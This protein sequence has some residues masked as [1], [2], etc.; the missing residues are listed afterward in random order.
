M[1]LNVPNYRADIDGLRAIAII[2]VVLFHM[3]PEYFGGGFVGVDIFFVISGF[4]ITSIILYQL[5]NNTFSFNEFYAKR[6]IRL[7]PSLIIVLISTGL[8]GYFALLPSEFESLGKHSA[9]GATFLS[10]LLLFKEVNYFDSASE[11]KPLLHL[12]SLGIEEQFYIF[13]PLVLFISFKIKPKYIISILAL[14]VVYSFS[15]NILK[16]SNKPEYSFYLPQTRFWELMIGSVLGYFHINKNSIINKQLLNFL[17]TLGF[18]LCVLSFSIIDKNYKFPGFWSLMPVIGTAFLIFSGKNTFINS[19]VLSHRF[20]VSI[21]LISYPLY[22]WHWPLL[23]FSY[24]SRNNTPPIEERISLIILS[25]ILS[26]LTY[27]IIEKPLIKWPIGKKRKKSWIFL[28]VLI[29]VF[30]LGISIY[31]KFIPPYSSNKNFSLI[32]EAVNDWDFPGRLKLIRNKKGDSIYWQGLNINKSIYIGDSNIQQYYP[33][34]EKLVNQ[35]KDNLGL[36]FASGGGCPPFPNL[37][38]DDGK[39]SFCEKWINN[40]FELALTDKNIKKVII[41]AQWTSYFSENSNFYFSFG[42]NKVYLSGFQKNKNLILNEF[43]KMIERL[44]KE[45]KKVYVVLN[46][47]VGPEF[48]PLSQIDRGF[49]RFPLINSKENKISRSSFES[50]YLNLL[51]SIE[52]ISKKSGAKIINPLDYLCNMKS[53]YCDVSIYGKPIYKDNCH[54]RPF[55]VKDFITFLD[56]TI[57]P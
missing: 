6:I 54:L 52:F 13:L 9:A 7:F 12:W 2:A 15:L 41:G 14:S 42:N 57:E 32:S 22:L 38:N 51:N 55:Y 34:L 49:S 10:N 18:L 17:S 35:S 56:E 33:R 8:I 44:I 53:T 21:G 16:I 23:S 47:P 26:I 1:S 27:K 5:K 30:F 3:A 4:L 46:I 28:A 29:V 19:K 36:L 48:A 50:R 11:M 40:G 45:N 24:I 25:F 39:Y 31:K 37:K 43:G 20:L